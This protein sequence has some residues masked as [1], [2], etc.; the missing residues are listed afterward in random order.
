M[1]SSP[2]RRPSQSCP[3]PLADVVRTWFSLP[4][5]QDATCLIWYPVNVKDE[6]QEQIKNEEEIRREMERKSGELE[7]E[8]KK[9]KSPGPERDR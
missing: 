6:L 9:M 4:Q 8:A 7:A 2:R 5:T 1:I 3:A